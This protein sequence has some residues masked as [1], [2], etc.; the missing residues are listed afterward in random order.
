M[1][2]AVS[3]SH[4]DRIHTQA[5]TYIDANLHKFIPTYSS[6]SGL[7]LLSTRRTSHA[8][9]YILTYILTYIN[10]SYIQQQKWTEAPEHKKIIEKGIPEGAPPGLVGRKVCM[11]VCIA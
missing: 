3:C 2:I 7:T 4:S 10:H 5:H 8:H 6:E 11:Y 1:P 9:T